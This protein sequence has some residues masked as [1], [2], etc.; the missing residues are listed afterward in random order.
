MADEISIA[1]VVPELPNYNAEIDGSW[2]ALDPE[3]YAVL[4]SGHSLAEA[5]GAARAKG[6]AHPTYLKTAPMEG[7]FIPGAAV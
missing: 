6:V 7:V 1:P 3:T 5:Q 2:I 4:G